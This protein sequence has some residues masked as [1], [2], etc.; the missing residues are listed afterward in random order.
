MQI[1]V[2]A[3]L[4][5]LIIL[6]CAS[7]LIHVNLPPH[8]HELFA[9]RL[10]DLDPRENAPE[11]SIILADAESQAYGKPG[12]V[13]DIKSLKEGEVIYKHKR[14]GFYCDKCTPNVCINLWCCRYNYCCPKGCCLPNAIACNIDGHCVVRTKPVGEI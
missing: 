2:V 6:T 12:L 5:S 3:F 9:R 1:T 14:G 10:P 11:G 7:S 13:R 8:P 4:P